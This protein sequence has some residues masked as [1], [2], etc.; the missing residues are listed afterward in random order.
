MSFLGA[1]ASSFFAVRLVGSSTVSTSTVTGS[2]FASALTSNL[3]GGL[4]LS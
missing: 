1:G 2:T 4:A 3:A